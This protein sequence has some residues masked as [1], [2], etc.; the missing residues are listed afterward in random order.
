MPENEF[1]SRNNGRVGDATQNHKHLDELTADELTDALS[2]MWDEMD[3]RNY[4]PAR[5]DAYLAKLEK[6]GAIPPEFD[7]DASL[8]AFQKKH[9]RLLEQITP[10]QMTTVKKP[11]RHLR[12]TSFVAAIVI[13]MLFCSLVT[14]QALGFD[15]FGAIARWTEETIKLSIFSKSTDAPQSVQSPMQNDEYASLIEALE[16]HGVLEPIAP[17]WYPEG[18]NTVDVSASPHPNGLTIR[19]HYEADSQSISVTIRQYSNAEAAI[20]ATGTFEKDA[21]SVIQYECNGVMHYI[22]SNNAQYTATWVNGTLVCA[23][24]G[25]LTVDEIERMI[26]SV[27]ER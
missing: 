13:I 16:K 26:D 20:V 19:A 2:D 14:A 11:V 27:Y 18:F 24:I 25:D 12:R 5:M 6:R 22:I 7:V 4:D 3:E 1:S 10:V 23:I 9:A 17:T 21:N 8:T 15:L